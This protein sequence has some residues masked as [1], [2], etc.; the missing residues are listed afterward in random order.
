MPRARCRSAAIV[1]AAAVILGLPALARVSRGDEAAAAPPVPQFERDIHPLLKTYCW[2]C[3]GGEGYEA[4]LDFRSLPLLLKGGK[5]GKVLEPGSA[6]KSK[7]YQKLAAKEMPPGESLKP[8][9]V[10]L[11]TIKAWID[12]GA[13]GRYA[14]GPLTEAEDPLLTDDDRSWWAFRKPVRHEPP[15]VRLAGRVRTPIDA[16]LLARLEAR[17]LTISPDADRAV[18]LRRVYFDLLGLPPSPQEIDAFLLDTADDAYD[19][20]IDRLLDSPHY[21]E[22]WG[23]HWLDAAGYV[24]TIGS[25]NDAAIIKPRD[26]AWRYRDY[27]VSS[28]NSDKPYDR[29]L[30]EQLAGDELV[31]WRNVEKFTPEIKELLIATGF[32]RSAADNT[33]EKELNTADIRHQI[34]YDTMQTF[35]TNVMGLTIHCA[36]CHSHKFDPIAQADF[37]RLLGIFT[38]A[39]NVQHWIKV[40]DRCLP[41]VSPREKQEIDK[42]NSDVDRQISELNRQVSEIQNPARQKL[43]DRKL[44]KIPEAIREDTRTAIETPAEKRNEVQKFLANKLGPQLAINPADTT[45]SLDDAGKSAVAQREGQIAALNG[46]RQS[47]GKIQALWDVAAAPAA[48]LYRRGGYE[49]PGAAVTPGFPLVLTEQVPA[50]PLSSIASGVSSGYRTALARWL[51]QTD[52]PLTSRVIVNR[53]WQQY[54]GRGIVSTP[55]NFGRS[56]AAPTHPELLDW[57]A[58]EFVRGGWKFKALHRLILKSSAYRQ[59]SQYGS[60]VAAAAAGDGAAVDPMAVDPDNTLLWRMPL[61]RLESEIIRDAA[62]AVSGKL[63][64]KL[65]GPAVPVKPLPDGMVV[66]E[67]QNLPAGMTPFRRTIYLVSR[68][69]YHPTELGVFDQPLIATNCVRRTS[70]A[71]AL[72]SLTMLNGQFITEQAEH[73]AKRVIATAGTDELKRI[74]LAFNLALARSPSSEELALSRLLIAKQFQ[75]LLEQPSTTPARADEQ[76]LAHMCHMLLNTNEFLYIQ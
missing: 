43:F 41:D 36:Q 33:I 59:S 60:P 37:Y 8:T 27:V 51:G 65:G 68:R 32:L 67:T 69:N 40:D 44:A 18:L 15:A 23:R 14:G 4:E 49:F 52:H 75:R 12:G 17:G 30:L 16:F 71:V 6:E 35:S 50:P 10:H 19:R 13:P 66:V 21:G 11:A 63:D 45:A 54:F 34:L 20:L 29:F 9:D 38:P 26:G 7:L 22:R 5:N 47:Y 55:E 57:L 72:Q 73:F 56:G 70:A 28:F 76:A 1:V 48:Y 58:T 74:E 3:H 61:R 39:L 25:D 46:S 62:L 31:D 2:K 53:V 64:R 24:D 42:H